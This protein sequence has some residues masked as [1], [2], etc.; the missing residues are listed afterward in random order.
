MLYDIF[1]FAEFGSWIYWGQLV[2]VLFYST[3]YLYIYND[4]HIASGS[5]AKGIEIIID[6]T[7]AI[8][9]RF[10]FASFTH[11]WLSWAA[12]T[13][14]IIL[15]L[16]IPYCL[17][18]DPGAMKFLFL[19]VGILLSNFLL[20]LFL[21]NYSPVVFVFEVF[22]AFSVYAYYVFGRQRRHGTQQDNK[23]RPK[24][25][26]TRYHQGILRSFFRRRI[27]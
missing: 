9:Y 8:L 21:H 27:K 10:A 25:E 6:A 7:V 23:R 1:S 4:L 11:L 19:V 18:R 16:F 2:V 5:S 3:D 15:L 22:A 12:G 14:L 26:S 17:R 13:F 20:S 24:S